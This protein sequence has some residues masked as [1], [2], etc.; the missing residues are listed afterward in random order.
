MAVRWIFE[1]STGDLA[2]VPAGSILDLAG[3]PAGGTLEN[4]KFRDRKS[5]KC[6][7]QTLCAHLGVGSTSE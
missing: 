4:P 7:F 5:K 6:P 1:K 3:V 2:G